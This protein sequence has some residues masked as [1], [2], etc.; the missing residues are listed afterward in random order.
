MVTV[1][2]SCTDRACIKA[3]V[4]P[5]FVDLPTGLDAIKFAFAKNENR[6]H[7][8]PSQRGLIAAR[9]ANLK[10]GQR[11][12]SMDVADSFTP[13]SIPEAAEMLGISTKTVDRARAVLEHGCVDCG[14]LLP[15]P[16]SDAEATRH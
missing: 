13:V 5:R 8:D 10:N 6:R 14:W 4:V 16:P 12:T 1:S 3:A 9:L 15:P 11:A 2:A 7:L